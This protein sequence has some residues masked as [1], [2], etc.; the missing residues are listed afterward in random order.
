MFER[1]HLGDKYSL[2]VRKFINIALKFVSPLFL[3][4]L[5]GALGNEV[6][7]CHS[8]ANG[9]YPDTSSVEVIWQLKQSNSSSEHSALMAML[10]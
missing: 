6:C 3:Q 1:Q 4:Q 10:V 7:V 9:N 2:L 8:R 5:P